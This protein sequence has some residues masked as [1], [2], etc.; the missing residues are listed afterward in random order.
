M[1]EM[2]D[3]TGMWKHIPGDFL[4]PDEFCFWIAPK[5]DELQ[6]SLIAQK[7]QEFLGFYL[8]PE[9]KQIILSYEVWKKII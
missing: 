4:K 2:A 5:P 1:T 3:F 8:I 9:D 6:L 7:M